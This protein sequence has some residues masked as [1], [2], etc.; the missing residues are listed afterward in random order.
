MAAKLLGAQ[1]TVFP[2]T[3]GRNMSLIDMGID[4]LFMANSNRIFALF[5][6][7]S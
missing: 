5:K 3:P 4:M 2:D 7:P 1:K 6:I